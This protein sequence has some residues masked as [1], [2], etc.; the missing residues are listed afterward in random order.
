MPQLK[1]VGGTK[2]PTGPVGRGDR[3]EAHKGFTAVDDHC[4]YGAFGQQFD[5]VF[6]LNRKEQ[7]A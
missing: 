4:G 1:Q 5:Q 2:V 3:I 7:I 6:V